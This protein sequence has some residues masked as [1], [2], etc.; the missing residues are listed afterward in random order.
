MTSIDEVRIGIIGVGQI[1]RHHLAT[2][3]NIPGARVV[4]LCDLDAA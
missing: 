1:G 3:Q 2:Y 4:A